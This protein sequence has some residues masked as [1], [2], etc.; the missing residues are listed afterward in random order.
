[1]SANNSN[2]NANAI[3]SNQDIWDLLM[4]PINVREDSLDKHP[5]TL[6]DAGLKSPD[7]LDILANLPKNVRAIADNLKPIPYKKFISDMNSRSVTNKAPFCPVCRDAGL[8]AEDYTSHHIWSDESRNTVICPTLLAHTCEKCGLKGHMPRYCNIT[9]RKQPNTH[10]H[11]PA[12]IPLPPYIPKQT[13]TPTPEPEKP[14][15]CKVCYQAG[16]GPEL[17]STHFTKVDGEILC[18]TILNNPCHRCGQLGHTPK[19]CSINVRPHQSRFQPPPTHH[20]TRHETRTRPSRFSLPPNTPPQPAPRLFQQEQNHSPTN[21]PTNNLTDNFEQLRFKYRDNHYEYDDETGFPICLKLTEELSNETDLNLLS[22]PTP[23]GP[24]HVTHVIR[25][26][27]KLMLDAQS[28][29]D[30]S[31]KKTLI[32]Q[33]ILLQ[34]FLLKII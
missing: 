25:D 22:T 4:D 30:L 33:S 29:K 3:V 34:Q 8:P 6:F 32:Q 18:P 26:S 12:P 1:M 19:Y 7:D 27:V 9:I 20:E 10:T 11:N 24:I 16:F 13:P 17:Y 5:K 28:A 14:K 2:S 15:H 21:T 23:F 31:Q